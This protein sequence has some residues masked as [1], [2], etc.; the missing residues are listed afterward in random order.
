M[1]T[2]ERQPYT[3]R[4]A[5][6]D[7]AVAKA[8]RLREQ[9]DGLAV[10]GFG[11][12]EL[13]GPDGKLKSAHPFANLVTQVG[14]QFYGDR[15][16]QIASGAKTLTAITNAT[17][18]VCTTSAAHGFGVGDVVTIAGVTPAGYNGSWAITA[19]GSTTTFSIYVGTA[20]GAGS[21]FGTATSRSSL[22]G[23]SG[24]KLGTGGATAVAKTGA[25]A[26]IVTYVTASQQ[27]L[28]G[29]FPTSALNGSSRRIQ[30][31]SSW[32]A[33]VATANGINEWTVAIDQPL[34][35]AAG[36]AADTIARAVDTGSPVNKAAGD[37]LDITWNHDLLGA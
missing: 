31:K 24:M 27:A 32:G 35:N 1:E 28:A 29:G 12:A 22:P 33:G 18:A 36:S 5:L 17:T 2:L 37:T 21:A 3:D 20:L 10:V 26:A 13:W 6:V 19:V 23:V 4:A 34:A 25:G 8:R 15:A 30:Y 11:I 14:D 7:Q 16:A 9:H